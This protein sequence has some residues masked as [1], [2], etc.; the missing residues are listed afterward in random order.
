MP[1]ESPL[2]RVLDAATDRIFLGLLVVISSLPL[3]T[4]LA[5]LTAAA[6]VT[7]AR[8]DE[9]P[10]RVRFREA[11]VGSVRPTLLVQLALVVGAAI[12]VLDL[13]YA[14]AVPLILRPGVTAVAVILLL[15][16]VVLPPYLAALGVLFPGCL[17]VQ[18]MRR[19]ALVAAGRPATSGAI[20]AGAAVALAGCW[21]VPVASPLLLG[22]Q[23]VLAVSL[24][25]RTLHACR[26]T[27]FA[28]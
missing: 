5:A 28:K 24:A 27:T 21:I 25:S 4:G 7:V 10:I 8:D 22:V 15:S 2:R 26:R 20:L 17:P 18:A 11:F 1:T 19:A 14:P 13:L 3:I 12:G 9:R 16:A 23:G 6:Q